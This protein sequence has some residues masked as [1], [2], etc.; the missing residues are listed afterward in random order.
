MA[1]RMNVQDFSQSDRL[2][3]DEF[4]HIYRFEERKIAKLCMP[5]Q[6]TQAETMQFVRKNTSLPVPEVYDAYVDESSNRGII[7]MEYVEG[8]ILRDVWDD[9][10]GEQQSSIAN[11]LKAYIREL[12]SLKGI[13]IGPVDGSPCYDPTFCVGEESFGPFATE[14]EFNEGLIKA[15]KL[16][17]HNSWVDHISKFVRALPTH[18]VVF[19]HGDISPRNIIVRGDQ[20][21]AILDWEMAGFYP[22]YWEYIKI[23][24]Y[25]DWQ[26]KWI[27]SGIVDKI[28]RPWPLEHA[29]LIHLQQV[30][31]GW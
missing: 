13:F 18:N 22:E 2:G 8:N 1:Q 7:V 21:V 27:T 16:T 23:L 17:R 25:P 10:T 19:T 4:V 5:A 6:V 30:I 11:Q 26:S 20:V 24:F 15:M 14:T 3:S 12:Q 29:I 31:Q 28:L 9:L